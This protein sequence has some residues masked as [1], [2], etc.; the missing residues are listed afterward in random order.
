M[1]LN[2]EA[3]RR[4]KYSKYAVMSVTIETCP[5]HRAGREDRMISSLGVGLA[6]AQGRFRTGFKR[7][8]GNLELFPSSA[9]P[10]K[11]ALII[12]VNGCGRGEHST[13]LF[14]QGL[15][16]VKEPRKKMPCEKAY[17]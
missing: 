17:P 7:G 1:R 8:M 15:F 3:K 6:M 5:R 16:K 13:H 14:Y 10:K 11:S 4:D 9:S 2:R 12:K